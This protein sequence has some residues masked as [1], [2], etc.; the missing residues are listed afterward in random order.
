M[1]KKMNKIKNMMKKLKTKWKKKNKFLQLEWSHLLK[2]IKIQ[3]LNFCKAKIIYQL[4]LLE[5][6][7]IKIL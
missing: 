7:M 4:I 2:I 1:K 6:M 3:I 5:K